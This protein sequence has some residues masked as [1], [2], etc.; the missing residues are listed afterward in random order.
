[1]PRIRKGGLLLSILFPV[2]L[3]AQAAQ[4]GPSEASAQD[5]APAKP[6]AFVA[7]DIH[8]SPFSYWGN[9]FHEVPFTGDR[10]Q[11]HRATPLDLITTAYH[12][13]PDVVTGGP[14]GLEFD[15][16]DI[17]AKA[18]PGATQADT[19]RMLQSLLADRFKLVVATEMKPLPAYLLQVGK[20]GQKMKPA[21]DPNGESG[22]RYQPP[23]PPP[24]PSAMSFLRWRQ[25]RLQIRVG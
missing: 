12:A 17:V 25:V 14:P 10:V 4:P 13:E 1:M 18:P 8:S 3:A 22:C 6:V 9:Y 23:D 21:A 7:A 16:Y 19:T 11:I 15:H 2:A 24:P 20:R 5:A